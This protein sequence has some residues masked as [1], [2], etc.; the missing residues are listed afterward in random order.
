LVAPTTNAGSVATNA[1][2]S[3]PVSI[4]AGTTYARFALFDQPGVTDDLDLE[5]RNSANALV[6]SSGGPTAAEQV[7]LVN[8]AAGNYTVTVV[9][10]AT[11]NATANFTL[12]N[13]LLGSTSA[14][15]MAVSAPAAATNGATAPITLTFTGLNPATKY[16]GSVAYSGATGLPNPTIVNVNTP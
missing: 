14:G 13:W 16:L 2:V 10:F 7:N 1:S 9:G 4:P 8:P 6:G 3:F 15:N 5:V 12:F 11:Q